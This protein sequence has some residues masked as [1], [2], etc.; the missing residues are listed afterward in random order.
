VLA[1]EVKELVSEI[2]IG[3]P[4]IAINQGHTVLV[5][6]R[7]GQIP[8]PSKRGLYFFDTR[9]LSNWRIYANGVRWQL[10]NSGKLFHYASRIFLT[11]ARIATQQGEIPPHTLECTKILT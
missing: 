10:L 1:L 2:T 3:P 11:N 6:D 8:F 4:Q 9:L 5:T 7:D